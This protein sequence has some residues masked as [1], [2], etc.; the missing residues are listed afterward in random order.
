[1][2]GEENQYRQPPLCLDFTPRPASRVTYK[3][4]R[5]NAGKERTRN[6]GYATLSI[7]LHM[8]STNSKII[9]Y[10]H[11]EVRKV[12][13]AILTKNEAKNHNDKQHTGNDGENNFGTGRRTY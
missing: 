8:Q 13:G 4:L 6:A 9:R 1:M 12:T 3:E 5:R 7:I 11:L 2:L 10:T